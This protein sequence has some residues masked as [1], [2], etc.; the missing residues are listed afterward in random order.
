[1]TKK[2]FKAAAG[3]VEKKSTKAPV[4]NLNEEIKM[5]AYLNFENSGRV[6]GNDLVHWYEAEIEVLA[7]N[8]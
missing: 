6:D 5:R 3:K 7:G 8:K 1:M 4:T 2:I